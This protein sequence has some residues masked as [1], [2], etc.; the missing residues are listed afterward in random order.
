MST[1]KLIILSEEVIVL[2]RNNY[3]R[4]YFVAFAVAI[5]VTIALVAVA[6]PSPSSPSLL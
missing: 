5:A 4:S 6:R 2:K 1:I 3:Y